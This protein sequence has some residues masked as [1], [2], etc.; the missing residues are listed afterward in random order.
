MRVI[1]R[2][3]PRTLA[4]PSGTRVYWRWRESN[5]TGT[6]FFG[7]WQSGGSSTATSQILSTAR[8]SLSPLTPITYYVVQASLSPTF[9]RPAQFGPFRSGRVTK[10][11]IDALKKLLGDLEKANADSRKAGELATAQTTLLRRLDQALIDARQAVSPITI[12]RRLKEVEDVG[13]DLETNNTALKAA[14]DTM[15]ASLNV[16]AASYAATS[17][18]VGFTVTFGAIGVV[19][20]STLFLTNTTGTALGLA[21]AGATIGSIAAVVASVLGV[22]TGILAIAGLI[23]LTNQL[24][25]SINDTR[26]AFAEAS[27]VER[28][29][30]KA[31][32]E[33]NEL[34]A[35]YKAA[36]VVFEKELAAP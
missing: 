8:A 16:F 28:D 10:K 12:R 6:Q 19:T 32:S 34:I 20:G 7:A 29:I 4:P 24:D 35:T 21:A 5:A 30:L 27:E 25:D 14:V 23:F 11:E 2:Q 9:S 31:I 15:I 3:G 18:E 36:I 33:S 1:A 26:E 17:V 13:D 22:V